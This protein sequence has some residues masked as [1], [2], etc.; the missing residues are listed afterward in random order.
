VTQ[1]IRTDTA[2]LQELRIKA[3]LSQ[4]ALARDCGLS[5]GFL[6]VEDLGGK[7]APSLDYG[8]SIVRDYLTP[9]LQTPA[10]PAWDPAAE[11]RLLKEKGLIKEDRDPAATVT[12]GE[13]ATVLNRLAR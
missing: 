4:R 13:L 1:V 2:R 6:S 10:S 12:W 5:N 3:G 11:I 7:W 8:G 9:M